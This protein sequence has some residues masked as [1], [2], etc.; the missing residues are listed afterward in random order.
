MKALVVDE[1]GKIEVKSVLPPGTYTIQFDL[2][3]EP[4]AFEALAEALANQPTW[5]R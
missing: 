2:A 5:P 1:L 3:V 4:G